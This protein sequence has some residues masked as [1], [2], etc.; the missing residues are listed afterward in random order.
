M[1]WR[2]SYA[3]NSRLHVI[4]THRPIYDILKLLK[5]NKFITFW[6]YF[7][8]SS[9][10]S[11]FNS[12]HIYT[13]DLVD[14]CLKMIFKK[15]EINVVKVNQNCLIHL[16]YGWSTLNKQ[17]HLPQSFADRK[18]GITSWWAQLPKLVLQLLGTF[19][20]FYWVWM[21]F[22][23]DSFDSFPFYLSHFSYTCMY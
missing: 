15:G 9:A 4:N 16:C 14:V 8:V 17:L 23:L 18:Q 5:R 12:L 2:F 6:I 19:L 21:L 22:D 3:S 11:S 13:P 7:K 1:K 20:K 10:K